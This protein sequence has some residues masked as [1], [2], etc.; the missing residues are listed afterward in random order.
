LYIISIYLFISSL[1]RAVILL[2]IALYLLGGV[3]SLDNGVGRT[4][5][6]GYNTW[7]DLGCTYALKDSTVRLTADA[8]IELGLDK[9]GYIYVNLDDCWS[10]GRDEKGVLYTDPIRFP[11]GI[12]PLSSY[13]HSKGLKFGIYTDRGVLTCAG[14]P[15]SYGREKLDAQ[16][17]ANWGVDF[18]KEDSCN[19]TQDHEAAFWQ[20]GLMR[21]A[22]N[23]TGRPMY[24][25][26]CGWNDWYAPVG[27]SLGNE[28]R[29]GPDDG[30]WKLIQTNINID[31]KLTQYAGPGGWNNPCLLLGIDAFGKAIITELQ[32]RFQFTM[33][34]ILAAP[35]MLST[36]IRMLSDYGLETYTNAEVIAVNQDLLGKQGFR[37]F[38]A[39][40]NSDS[41]TV[42]ANTNIWAR[43]LL[44]KSWAVAFVNVGSNG[45]NIACDRTCFSKI[46]FTVNTRFRAR[47]LW[48]HLDLGTYNATVYTAHSVPG[49][50]GHV[51][52]K[53][54]PL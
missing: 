40:L 30:N 23:A 14:A 34:S 42:T 51:L 18:V 8:I 2:C 10:E 20:Y 19:A 27:Y 50:G 7:Y 33:W 38:G 49:E 36:N 32:S 54:T 12:P 16:T 31:S 44:D 11:A 15:G 3:L 47:D 5:A 26:I 29:I 37:I 46:G 22:M 35:L 43:Q 48:Q 28:W 24:F 4:P 53:F 1:M 41:N 21:D 45:A 13:I 17:F 25:D 6:M 52:L 9:L 39:D